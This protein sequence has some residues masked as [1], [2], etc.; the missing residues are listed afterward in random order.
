MNRILIFSVGYPYGKSEPFLQDEME[1]HAGAVVISSFIGDT[2]SQITRWP[3]KTDNQLIH[4]GDLF[5]KGNKAALY[6]NGACALFSSVFWKELL[7]EDIKPINLRKIFQLLSC[8]SKARRIVKAVEKEYIFKETEIPVFYAYWMN[9]LALASVILAEKHHGIA[10]SRCHGYDLYKRTENNHYVTL[11]RYLTQK[12]DY[13]FPVSQDGKDVLDGLLCG[14]HS[15]D[16]IQVSRL[17]TKDHG[18]G[19]EEREAEYF[20]IVSCSNVVPLKRVGLILDAVRNVF[21]LPIR[22]VHFGDGPLLKELIQKAADIFSGSIHDVQ[23]RGYTP[24]NE[25]MRFYAENH[26]DIFI[27][28]SESEGIPVSIMEAQ[29]FGIPCIGTDVGGMHEIINFENGWLVKADITGAE[30]AELII[31]IRAMDAR[32]YQAFR[33]NARRFWENNYCADVNYTQFVEELNC[34]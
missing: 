7:S 30:L 25:L 22:W 28:V 13:I 3:S 21:D 9:Q 16:K 1:Y 10:V 4:P 19:P 14:N 33:K 8:I 32:Q 23:L 34:I 18:T 5:F 6:W 24:K 11:Q 27:N 15:A 20:T 12:L 17:G 2:A 31:S 29:S 26:V